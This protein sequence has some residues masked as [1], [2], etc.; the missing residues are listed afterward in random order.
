MKKSKKKVTSKENYDKKI[1]KKNEDKKEL[2]HSA[3]FND[4]LILD[5]IETFYQE[6]AD[7]IVQLVT[8]V[9]QFKKKQLSAGELAVD[10]AKAEIGIEQLKYA[11]A[12]LRQLTVLNKVQELDK[13]YEYILD[14]SKE[15]EKE[16]N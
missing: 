9:H 16:N 7:S 1:A 2:I 3:M 10:L 15:Y 5:G 4:L 12:P 11:C 14:R 8:S 6:I 13:I